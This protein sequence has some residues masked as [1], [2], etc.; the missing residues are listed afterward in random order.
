MQFA[1]DGSTG[2]EVEARGAKRRREYTCPSCGARV[3]LRSGDQYEP[4]FAH[5]AHEGSAACEEYFPGQYNGG[6]PDARSAPRRESE[7]SGGEAS[8]CVE[9]A[10]DSWNVYLRLPEVQDAAL[11]SAPI[12]ALSRASVKV[13]CGE[14]EV[15]RVPGWDVRPRVGVA[16]AVVPPSSRDYFASATGD[17]P[18]GVEVSRWSCAV[19]GL[20]PRGTLFRLRAGEWTRLL[21]GSVVRQGARL[22]AV[23]LTAHEPPRSCD[24]KQRDPISTS[25]G[26]W[27]LWHVAVRDHPGPTIEGWLGALGHRLEPRSWDLSLLSLP[28]KL[29][30]DGRTK[31]FLAGAPVVAMITPPSPC[32][33]AM[34]TLTANSSTQTTSICADRRAAPVFALATVATANPVTLRVSEEREA[35][36]SFKVVT[37][38]SVEE[39]RAQITALPRLRV[40]VGEATLEPWSDPE[41]VIA[42]HRGAVDVR[43][44]VGAGATSVDVV[45]AGPRGRRVWTRLTPA[46][47]AQT[48]AAALQDQ[49]ARDVEVDAGALGRVAFKARVAASDAGTFAHS[50][51]TYAWLR[52]VSLAASHLGA[53]APLFSTRLA[54]SRALRAASSGAGG[55]AGTHLRALARR[56]PRQRSIK[57]ET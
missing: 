50:A 33:Q 17:W 6:A 10:G 3:F 35:A 56:V 47:A 42:R 51:R 55:A 40:T 31:Q 39:L 21:P 23:A 5:F 43:V 12:S 37:P 30:S 26:S 25:T 52:T 32:A 15:A 7:A 38:V 13:S 49:S 54:L 22:I 9:D 27:C 45:I 29:S 11:T 36:L 18:P 41:G 2:E 8:L 4:H 19:R 34:L 57:G 1:R 14:Q 28:Y 48:I 44:D 20:E 46:D 24:P 16:R 53:T